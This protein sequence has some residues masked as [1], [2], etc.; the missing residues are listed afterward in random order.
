[1]PSETEVRT[2]S[3]DDLDPPSSHF[4]RAREL[5]AFPSKSVTIGPVQLLAIAVLERAAGLAPR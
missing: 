3:R 2:R 5:N 4:A 1:M